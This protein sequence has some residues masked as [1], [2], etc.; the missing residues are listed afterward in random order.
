MNKNISEIKNKPI[1]YGQS[2]Y[3][4]ENGT[5]YTIPSQGILRV[6]GF[7]TNDMKIVKINNS[8]YV[9]DNNTGAKIVPVFEGF[10]VDV[11]QGAGE[12]QFF[13]YT[14]E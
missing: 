11:I 12:I 7:D 5:I 1:S 9:G 13:P 10:V 3:L 2:V 6:N 4:N 8:L 14:F